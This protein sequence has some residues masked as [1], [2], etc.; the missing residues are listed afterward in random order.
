MNLMKRRTDW[1][2]NI[3]TT[4]KQ[5]NKQTNQVK[6]QSRDLINYYIVAP[7]DRVLRHVDQT[8]LLWQYKHLRVIILCCIL[9]LQYHSMT[10]IAGLCHVGKKLCGILT[11][12]G[13][14]NMYSVLQYVEWLLT[15]WLVHL[16]PQ[17][18]CA[19]CI[20]ILVSVLPGYS[21]VHIIHNLS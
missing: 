17:M 19:Q 20:S 4:D 12:R 16:T 11:Q 8:L 14:N 1:Q 9:M 13:N 15:A 18:I 3:Q 10:I 6:S 2:T 5:T 7:S 21:V